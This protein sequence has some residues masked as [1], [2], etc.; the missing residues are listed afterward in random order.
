MA[1]K[2][3][4]LTK[5]A[6]FYLGK[7]IWRPLVKDFMPNHHPPSDHYPR[8]LSFSIA[9]SDSPPVELEYALLWLQG[10]RYLYPM[11]VHERRSSV[12]AL[13]PVLPPAMC[14][15]C[16]TAT[17]GNSFLLPIT[18]GPTF[19]QSSGTVAAFAEQSDNDVVTA[20]SLAEQREYESSSAQPSSAR[21]ATACRNEVR[22]SIDDDSADGRASITVFGSSV[23]AL[24]SCP[25]STI[26]DTMATN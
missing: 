12:C 24:S 8:A 20:H 16:Q 6:A 2:I 15:P 3:T 18:T 23:G 26:A 25:M 14:Q 19:N 22:S 11:S 21:A 1:K 13:L 17:A 10:W 5:N 9:L 7:C 4:K